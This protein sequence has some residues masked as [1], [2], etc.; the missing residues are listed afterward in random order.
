MTT[1]L[2]HTVIH[3]PPHWGINPA[4]W[5]TLVLP[6][7]LI[8]TLFSAAEAGAAYDS[9]PSDTLALHQ[10][11]EL[12][13]SLSDIH[14]LFREY[15][16]TDAPGCAVA[17]YQNGA[18]LY[19]N[20]FGMANLDYQI[21]LSDSSAFYMASISKQVTAAAAGLLIVRGEIAPDDPVSDYLDNWPDW[22]EDVR[23]K[24][25]FNHTSG[26]PDLYDIMEIAGISLSNVMDIDD[27]IS[28]IKNGES[29]KHQPG[30]TYSY[31]NSGY[32][33]LAK[34]IENITNNDFSVF[35]DN[36][37]LQPLGMSA[38]HFHDDRYRVIANRVISYAPVE[39]RNDRTNHDEEGA[40]TTNDERLP[41]YR[42][43][44]LGNFQGVGP[45]GLYST[46]RDWRHWE[47]FWSGNQN[48]PAENTGE[49]EA[50]KQLMTE[51]AVVNGDTL[52]YGMGLEIETWQ[53]IRMEGHPG[54][55][56]GFRTDVR[57][58][59]EYGIS[60][61]TLCNR[62]DADPPEMNRSLARM[63]LKEKFEAFLS[64][65]GGIYHNN[66]LDV[67]YELTVEQGALKLNRRLSPS[68]IM[69]EA[70]RDIWEAGSWDIVFQRDRNNRITGF[71]VSTGRTREVEF[72]K[73]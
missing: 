19:R 5:L 25:L 17:I 63:I 54:S 61:I 43:T 27:Y 42:Q 29:L 69:S 50:L 44:Y 70:E 7:L 56:M 31:T 4:F 62:E 51:R 47:A 30:N 66:E 59:P 1:H 22:A 64:P 52:D 32:T 13:I 23:V 16:R 11:E 41:A 8:T 37:I 48:L 65:Y 73:Q 26:L 21:P 10:H 15:D 38:T 58:F 39:E 49:F 57:R 20:G 60:I 67:K 68:G 14:E 53:G 3:P 72:R 35:V 9:R 46:L 2:Q 12:E 24:H 28:V 55:F 34:I 33:A 36:E 71:L 18:T 40:G 45:G 6:V